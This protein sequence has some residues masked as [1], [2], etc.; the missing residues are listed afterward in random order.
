MEASM[1]RIASHRG[2]T[3]EFGDS[4]PAG[5]KATAQMALEE[6]EFDLHPTADG[7]IMVHHDATLDRTTDRTGAICEMSEAEVRA[8]TI[9]YGAGSHPL[10][11]QE[12]CAI[13]RG[14]SVDFRCEIKP[15][16]DRRPYA[17]FVPKVVAVL[18]AEGMLARTV[19]S[20]FLIETLD[21]LAKVTDRPRLWLVSPPVLQQLGSAGT[22]EV[23][24]AHGI[25][26]IGVQID[27]ADEVLMA[28]AKTAGL[29]FGCWAAHSAEQI[30][31]ALRLGVKVFTTD[32]PSLAVEIRKGM[33]QE[34]RS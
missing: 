26:E 7:A 4:T 17:D 31:K 18:A 25:P 22:L 3:L 6:V 16:P 19:F 8:A 29:Q 30:E 15:G 32:R 33:Q 20:S 24:K 11:L 34:R 27:C 23:A 12:L 9:D 10:S 14:S 5:F 13:Y 1:T 2:G 28:A 21:E